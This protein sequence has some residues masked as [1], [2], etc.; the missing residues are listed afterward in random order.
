MA[1]YLLLVSTILYTYKNGRLLVTWKYNFVCIKMADYWLFI[2]TILYTYKNGRL[3][4]TCKY[5]F[6]CIKMANYW[7]L[8]SMYK[9]I[10]TMYM[11]AFSVYSGFLHQ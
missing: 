1:D 3:F 5:N 4:V 8:V 9:N 6:V 11:S 7:L 2:S 10:T